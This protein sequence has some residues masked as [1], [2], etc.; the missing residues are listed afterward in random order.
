M[1]EEGEGRKEGIYTRIVWRGAKETAE[2]CRFW[3]FSASAIRGYK[4]GIIAGVC[5]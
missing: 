2:F 5:A 1:L 3:R 4:G